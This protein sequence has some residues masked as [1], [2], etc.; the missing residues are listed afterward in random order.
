MTNPGG[1]DH[2]G[3]HGREAA[4]AAVASSGTRLV[5][6]R[7]VRERLRSRSMKVSTV[8]ALLIVV[9]G[10]A[11]PTL[12]SGRPRTFDV[13]VVGQVSPAMTTAIE[14]AA[15]AAG[16]SVRLR[17]PPSVGQ[18]RAAVGRGDLDLAVVPPT[19]L[20]TDRA[21]QPSD[22]SSKARLVR[23]VAEAVRLQ[24]GL[25]R[26]GLTPDRAA[27]A[28]RTP[29]P[30]LVSLRP[31]A[32]DDKS[33][34]TALFGIILLYLLLIQYGAWVLNGVVEEKTSR[35]VEVLLSTITPRQLLVG[36]VVGIGAVALAQA[37]LLLVAAV[38][39][40]VVT[41]SDV[42]ERTSVAAMWVMLLW[43][44][45]GYSFYCCVY[46]AAG[47][48]VSRQE[49]AQNASFP[50]TIPL[51]VSYLLSFTILTGSDPSPVVRA[52]SWFPPTAPFLVPVLYAVGE[53]TLVQV[54]ASAAVSVAGIVVVVRTAAAIYGRAVLRT[55]QRIRW[56]QALRLGQT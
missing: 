27:A 6:G 43:F 36:K 42:L 16:G 26:E 40:A 15:A 32:A 17:R 7:E 55:G 34:V 4:L 25:E 20:I 48:L 2:G 14:Q 50:V 41:G 49:D 35:V 52:L 18:A 10:V 3:G 30:Q 11:L 31:A 23:A 13:G 51:L 12:R 22:T 33:R 53:A 28:L 1:G 46:A 38:A 56:R 5:A 47:A 19:Q 9:G 54:F 39:T 29:P 21:L 44:V 37:V 24:A 8:L 45:L